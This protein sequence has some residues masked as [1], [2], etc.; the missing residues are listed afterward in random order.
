MSCAW[1]FRVNEA[2]FIFCLFFPH[3]GLNYSQSGKIFSPCTS[4][5]AELSLTIKT[6]NILLYKHQ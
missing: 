4:Y 5:M 6:D 3:P 2:F 1:N